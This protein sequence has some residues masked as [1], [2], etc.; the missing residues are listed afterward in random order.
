ML[1][2]G[3][4]VSSGTY[5]FGYQGQEM[6]NAISA[7]GQ[8]LNHTY[9]NYDSWTA[10]FGA[11]DPLAG[12]YPHNSTYAF[13]ENRVIDAVELE[14]LEAAFVQIGFRA[15]VPLFIISGSTTAVNIG[16]AAD[17]EGNIG[18]YVTPSLGGQVGIGL[19]GGISAGV[20]V[21]ADNI[22]DL[23]GWGV[24]FGG[25]V[26]FPTPYEFS[27]E[28]NFALEGESKKPLRLLLDPNTKFNKGANMGLP[29]PLGGGTAGLSFYGEMAYTKYFISTNIKNISML[30][31]SNSI[32]K[33]IQ[34]YVDTVKDITGY[35]LEEQGIKISELSNHVYNMLNEIG[36]IPSVQLPVVEI[37][38]PKCDE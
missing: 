7:L 28:V 20:N 35:G 26:G 25:F 1:Q 12:K 15:S 19:A 21:D 8:H 38:A 10:R 27:G 23:G 37:T 9:R 22:Y 13:S 3:R 2:P 16:I 31:A 5:R 14:G 34:K 24:N 32:E 17:F 18:I 4:S 29:I 6:D 33:T 11:I 30:S 36:S